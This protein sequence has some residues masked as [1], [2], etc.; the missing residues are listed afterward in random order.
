MEANGA[1]KSAFGTPVVSNE[2]LKASNGVPFAAKW[3]LFAAIRT[4]IAAS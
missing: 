1:V 3:T 4:L 2:V